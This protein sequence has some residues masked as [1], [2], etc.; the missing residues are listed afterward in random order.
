MDKKVLQKLSYGVYVVSAMDGD[1]PTGC[2]VNTVMQIT[3]SPATVAVSVH[4]DN[5]THDCIVKSGRFAVSI[6]SQDSDPAVIA[7]FGFRSGR[8]TDKFTMV[9]RTD[10]GGMPVIADAVGHLT[11]RVIGKLETDTHTVFLGEV[12]DAGMASATQPMTYA[13]YHEVVKGKSPKNAPTYQE[14]TPPKQDKPVYVCSVCGHVYDG[15]IPFEELP[16]DW[17]CPV[18]KQPKSVFQKR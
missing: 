18:C 6:L 15:D 9:K 13:Y 17:V 7:A 8:D 5:Y 11:C 2:V 4:H 1:R 16:E 3:S 14:E 12:E 10:F